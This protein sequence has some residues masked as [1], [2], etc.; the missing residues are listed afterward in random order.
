MKNYPLLTRTAVVVG[1]ALLLWVPLTL[2]QGV[3]TERSYTYHQVINDIAEKWT[4]QQRVTGPFIVAEYYRTHTRKVWN[5]E[6]ERYEQEVQKRA[7]RVAFLPS[8][9]DVRSNIDTQIREQGIYPVPV[10][11]TQSV[12][13]G[14]FD[15][16]E[17]KAFAAQYSDFSGW[18]DVW[19]SL[20]I[21][22]ERGIA[23]EPKLTVGGAARLFVPGPALAGL[24]GGIKAS[25]KDFADLPNLQFSIDL[26]LR[27]SQA[28]GFVPVARASSYQLTADWPHPSFGG[29][30]LPA[31]HDISETGFTANWNLTSFSSA[32]DRALQ[33][34]LSESQSCGELQ[35]SYF[36]IRLFDSVDLYARVDRA[37]KYGLL[38]ILITFLAFFLT[39]T[40]TPRQLHPFHYL[41]VGCSLAIFFL[42]LVS[43]AEHIGFGAAYT[44]ATAA[45]AALI[46]VYLRSVL[47]SFA[48]GA[49][50]GG[51]ITL[52]FG[53]LYT[54]LRSEDYALL[55]GTFLLFGLLAITMLATRGVNWYAIG[56]RL[57]QRE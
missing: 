37:V 31:E 1:L 34:C 20:G 21:T 2:I 57:N 7:F 51:A 25:L 15:Q 35:N 43:L 48:M 47:G 5:K 50:Y 8:E 16:A 39:E 17:L 9:L 40:L 18:G 6:T 53:M 23:E 54:I 29:R 13:S 30:F 45:C 22:D 33:K 38:F 42:L 55:M 11:Q 52:V 56:V 12:F 26:A 46:T 36:E 24:S 3:V 41:L 14:E 27:G 28:L 44:V 32:A 4:G 10:Y 19:L 49:S